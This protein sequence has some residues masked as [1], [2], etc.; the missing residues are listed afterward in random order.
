MTG[1]EQPKDANVPPPPQKGFRMFYGDPMSREKRG[2][3]WKSQSCFRCFGKNFQG[4]NAAPCADPK[5]DTETFPST[6]CPGGA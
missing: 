1:G 2:S 5:L 4:D 6:P 3:G